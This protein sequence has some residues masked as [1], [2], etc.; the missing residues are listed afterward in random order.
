M[1]GSHPTSR[2][3]GL[4]ILDLAVAL[5]RRAHELHITRFGHDP[6]R[7]VTDYKAGLKAF[8]GRFEIHHQAR[9]E[10]KLNTT[11]EEWV[12]LE[13]RAKGRRFNTVRT[14]PDPEEEI[15]ASDEVDRDDSDDS[16]ASGKK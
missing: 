12:E 3:P 11:L 4:P 8:L 13:A 7:P 9:C 10:Q 6:E 5:D 2:C 15:K 1:N 14:I 16:E